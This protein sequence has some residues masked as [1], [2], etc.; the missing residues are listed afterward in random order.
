[1]THGARQ[2]LLVKPSLDVLYCEST[3]ARMLRIGNVKQMR[4]CR[5]AEVQKII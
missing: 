5:S 3:G 1:M 2:H 4:I